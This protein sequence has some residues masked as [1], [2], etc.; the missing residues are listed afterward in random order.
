MSL[1]DYVRA[2]RRLLFFNRTYSNLHK[3]LFFLTLKTGCM[4]FLFCELFIYFIFNWSHFSH[5]LVLAID[6][7]QV[8]VFGR[9]NLTI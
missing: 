8:A 5:F 2:E 1:I 7:A 6:N 4:P 9:L 3:Y